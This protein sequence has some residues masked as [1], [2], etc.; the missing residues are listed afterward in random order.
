MVFPCEDC[1]I[2]FK[3]CNIPCEDTKGHRTKGDEER[4]G[5]EREIATPFLSLKRLE[6]NIKLGW[7]R[8]FDKGRGI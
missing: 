1:N 3:A 8:K 7:G 5:E 4:R 2:P 6:T